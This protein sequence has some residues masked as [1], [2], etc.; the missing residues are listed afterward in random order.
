MATSY[1][2]NRHAAPISRKQVLDTFEGRVYISDDD[3]HKG[4]T[5]QNADVGVNTGEGC[6]WITFDDK[7]NVCCLTTYADTY[8]GDSVDEFEAAFGS[9]LISE[10]DN[11]FDYHDCEI[12]VKTETPVYHGRDGWSIFITPTGWLQMYHKERSL[13]PNFLSEKVESRL[14]EKGNIKFEEYLNEKI[15]ELDL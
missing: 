5:L 11:D 7:D 2:L 4:L 12:D 6:F 9:V 8:N 14:D 3:E 13:V 1:I 10:H 15:E